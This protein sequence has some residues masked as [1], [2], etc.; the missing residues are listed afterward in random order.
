MRHS[1]EYF[2]KVNIYKNPQV[3][4]DLCF[5]MASDVGLRFNAFTGN[6]IDV[7]VSPA[8]IGAALA[9]RVAYH[10]AEIYQDKVV[11]LFTEKD[12]SD[13]QVL[14]R[15]FDKDVEGKNV[16]V[17]DDVLTTGGSVRKI[18]NEV[19]SFGGRVLVV[20]VICNR[21]DVQSEDIYELPLIYLLGLDMEDWPEEECD[22]CKEKVPINIDIG[23]GKEFIRLH[24][25]Y[26]SK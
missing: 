25:D 24:P 20:G 17:V 1:G 3:F 19:T 12:A 13:D 7:V 11:C 22:L 14:K 15:G 6:K 8:P 18:I 26:P 4:D 2:E 16:L 21:G 23:K 10:L 9:Q 5:E